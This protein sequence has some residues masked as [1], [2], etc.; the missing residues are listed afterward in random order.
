MSRCRRCLWLAGFSI[1]LTVVVVAC[2][3]HVYRMQQYL[4]VSPAPD[5]RDDLQTWRL[6]TC[7][8]CNGGGYVVYDKASK[9]MKD[10]PQFHGVYTC[11]M[12]SGS[13]QLY[14]QPQL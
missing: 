6:V 13:G 4:G 14:E 7:P 8:C 9:I 2:G 10:L 3:V 12:C 11:P 1:L 5:N